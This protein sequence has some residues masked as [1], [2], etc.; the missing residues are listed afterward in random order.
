MAQERKVYNFKSSGITPE[1]SDEVNS[2][3]GDLIPL[4]IATPIQLS[5]NEGSLFEMHTSLNKQIR[6]NFKNMLSTNRGER[7]MLGDFGADLKPLVYELGS[8]SGDG[9]AISRISAATEKFMPYI[10]L[11]TFESIN[12]ETKDG[13]L[14]KSGVRVT[15]TVPQMGLTE[16]TVEVILMSAG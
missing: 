8:D 15:Y 16:Q 6:D 11:Q 3:S 7:L 13:T 10:S 2:P 4:G 5:S 14:V 1:I 12:E 9:A